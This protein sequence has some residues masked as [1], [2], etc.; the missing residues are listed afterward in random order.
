MLDNSFLDTLPED[1]D[2]SHYITANNKS[3]DEGAVGGAD[4]GDPVASSSFLLGLKRLDG[5]ASYRYSWVSR[6]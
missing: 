3:Y 6:S 2:P 1:D 5:S 4:A